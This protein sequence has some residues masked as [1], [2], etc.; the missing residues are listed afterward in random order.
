MPLSRDVS[1]NRMPTY[2]PDAEAD[3]QTTPTFR[4]WPRSA[5]AITYD[6]AALWMHTLERHLGWPTMQRVMATYYER[7]KFRHPRPAGLLPGGERGERAGPHVVLRRGLRGSNT[8]DYAVQELKSEAAGQGRIRSTVAVQRLGEATFPVEV[9]TTFADGSQ[10]TE[11]WDGKDRRVLYSYDRP[12][13]AVRVEVDPRAR[14][15]AR[16]Q[17]HQQHAHPQPRAADAARKWSPHVDGLA[18]GADDHRRVL[19][20]IVVLRAWSDGWRRVA[21][22][23]RHGAGL[24]T[25]SRFL[26]ALPLAVMLRDQIAAQLGTSLMAGAVADG[27]SYDWW[28]E[29]TAQAGGLGTTFTPSIIGFGSTL[30][31]LS[32]VL[33]ARSP[34]ADAVAARRLSRALDVPE[35]RHPRSLRAAAADLRARLLRR[36]G[37]PVLPPRAAGGGRGPRLLAALPLRPPVAVPRSL[38][39]PHARPRRRARRRCCGACCSTRS[40]AR[41]CSPSISSSTTR[42]SAWWWRIAAASLGA[43]L[44]SLRFVRRHPLAVAGLYALNAL[45]FLV[46][47]A[48]WSLAAPGIHGAG[49]AMWAAFAA[50]QLYLLARLAIKLHFLSS[51]TALFQAHLAHATYTAAPRRAWPDSPAAELIRTSSR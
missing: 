41:R 21:A 3:A 23:R 31:A 47:L 2:R 42:A 14:A 32:R 11:H 22:R 50:G 48:A 34:P 27:V 19:R 30:D 25:R 12:S 33:D 44:A 43:L 49:P 16:R 45:V 18:P 1:G 36:R 7:W 26:L 5:N 29:F 28:T 37:P 17:P 39:R 6:K 35:R 38:S 46:L 24:C 13:R 15:A 51:Q 4:Y 10:A 20:L 40:S 9:V 8:F